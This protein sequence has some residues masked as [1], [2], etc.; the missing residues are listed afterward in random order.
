MPEIFNQAS[1]FL[2]FLW[3]L[4]AVDPGLKIAGVTGQTTLTMT[5]KNHPHPDPLPRRVRREGREFKGEGEKRILLARGRKK[6][7]WKRFHCCDFC[8]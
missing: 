4:N 1:M 7:H 6:K 2:L 5:R 3:F 8:G